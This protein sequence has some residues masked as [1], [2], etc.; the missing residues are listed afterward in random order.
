MLSVLKPWKM[1]AG[2]AIALLGWGLG[3]SIQS[4]S[5]HTQNDIETELLQEVLSLESNVLTT[6]R[7]APYSQLFSLTLDESIT[8]YGV[9]DRDFNARYND[10]GFY[11]FW[12][13][14]PE[15]NFLQ[16]AVFYCF[17]N[18]DLVGATLEK[19][20]LMAGDRPLV[21]LEQKAIATPAQTVEVVPERYEPIADPFYDP[22]WEPIYHRRGH[23]YNQRIRTIRVSAVECSMGGTRFDLLPVKAAIAQ[24]PE[25]T[26]EVQ[27]IFS[28]GLVENWR[29][30]RKTVEQLKNLPTLRP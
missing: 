8:G 25:E 16:A 14:I 20:I 2:V 24:L 27:L 13:D 21:T 3:A 6:I 10:V 7:K 1:G 26:L 17:R 5:A 4:A 28:N 19:A 22:F 15:Q 23:W 29:L 12:G 30:G 18:P 11:S 9:K